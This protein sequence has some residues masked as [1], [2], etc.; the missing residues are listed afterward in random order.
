MLTQ[1]FLMALFSR[2]NLLGFQPE[3]LWSFRVII[4]PFVQ[5]PYDVSRDVLHSA[6]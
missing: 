1:Y 2:T 6:S 4:Q 5:R 3:S